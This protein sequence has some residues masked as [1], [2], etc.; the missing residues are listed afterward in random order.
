GDTVIFFTGSNVV[1]MGDDFF[2]GRFPFVDLVSG[3]DVEGLTK[4]IAEVIKKLPADVKF[5]PGHGPVSTLDDL[6]TYHRMLIETTNIVREAMA[7]GKSLEE[8]KAVGL[9]EEWSSW[10]SGFIPAE[11]WLETIHASLS[12]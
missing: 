9:P 6:K 12:R 2:S 11:R 10:G 5:I 1:H 4:N 3:G 8:I 7:A